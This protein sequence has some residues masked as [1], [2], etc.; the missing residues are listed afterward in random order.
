VTD[1]AARPDVGV[2]SDRIRTERRRIDVARFVHED[3][4]ALVADAVL[5]SGLRHECSASWS[6]GARRDALEAAHSGWTVVSTLVAHSGEFAATSTA[7]AYDEAANL[8]VTQ[9]E[10][11]RVSCRV[12]AQSSADAAALLQSI[13]KL[14]PESANTGDE[15]TRVTFWS[16]SDREVER[17]TRRI[18][19]PTWAAVKANYHSRTRTQLDALVHWTPQLASGK[20]ILW[21]GPPG[22]GKTWALRALLR[23]WRDWAEAHYILDPEKF[24]G[25][26]ASY[27]M[28]V[29]LDQDGDPDESP[30]ARG[31]WRLLLVEDAAELVGTD[32]RLETGQGLARLL[33]VCDG[34]V[35]QGLRV[36]ILL[37]TN[38]DM[39]KMHPAVT[40]RG[41]CIADI[42]FDLLSPRESQAWAIAHGVAA[43]GERSA[44]LADL[45][46]A[47]QILTPRSR[48]I[49]GFRPRA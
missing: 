37:T 13:R 5:S 46:A 22:T 28:S 16:Y 39:G 29:I 10:S 11:D 8:L 9:W 44:L 14:L 27:M 6:T 45:F 21:H 25:Q 7:V 36:L 19:V 12:L 31:R 35:G 18:A 24:F 48:P 42:R 32:A 26:S 47:D 33:N 3:H 4:D 23:E 15:D 1:L 20:L 43:G 2:D 41:R 17:V 34:L 40:R 49:T 38:E 30:A